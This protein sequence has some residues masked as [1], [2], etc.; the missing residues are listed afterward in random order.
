M[1]MACTTLVRMRVNEAASVPIS[2]R[3]L[4]SNSAASRTYTYGPSP[5][6]LAFG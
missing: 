2:S 6:P 3:L 4:L 1:R 5:I